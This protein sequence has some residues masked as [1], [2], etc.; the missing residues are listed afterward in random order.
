[1]ENRKK[2]TR[3]DAVAVTNKA[4]DQARAAARALG[5]AQRMLRD[6]ADAGFD[7]LYVRGRD[8]VRQVLEA[9]KLRKKTSTEEL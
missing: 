9:E 8:E 3:G 6:V 1:M 2:L 4:V 5:D 7:D